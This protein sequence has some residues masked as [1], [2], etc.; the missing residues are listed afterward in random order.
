MQITRE[1]I[2]ADMLM[3]LQK[4]ADDWEYGGDI[5]RDTYLL[6]DMGFESLDVV[7]LSTSMQ[8]YYKQALPFTDLFAEIGRREQRDISIG[9]WV[10]FTYRHLN[11]HAAQE[12]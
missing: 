4:L 3:L 1:K 12:A 8:E 2:Q 7:I 9:E 6:S 11:S 10:D 5:T